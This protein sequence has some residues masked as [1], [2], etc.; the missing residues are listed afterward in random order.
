MRKNIA[1]QGIAFLLAC[2][3]SAPAL[4]GTLA[5]EAGPHR[6]SASLPEVQPTAQGSITVQQLLRGRVVWTIRLAETLRQLEAAPVIPPSFGTR[7]IVDEP[8]PAGL[9]KER[10]RESEKGQDR[11]KQHEEAVK[12]QYTP[13][14][15][16]N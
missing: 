10:D 12:K 13:K 8:D 15:D 2:V 16:L 3:T 7:T 1:W 11:T 14:T 4:A 5:S 6:A 9:R